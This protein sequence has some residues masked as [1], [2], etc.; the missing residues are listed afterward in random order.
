MQWLGSIRSG[1]ASVRLTATV[2]VTTVSLVCGGAWAA[3][4]NPLDD[5]SGGTLN[6]TPGNRHIGSAASNAVNSDTETDRKSDLIIVPIPGANPTIGVSLALAAAYFY[7]LDERSQASYT[8]IGA[9][10][11]TNGSLGWGLTQSISWLNDRLRAQAVIG[12]ADVRY[13]LY[14]VGSSAGGD[15]LRLPIDEPD[16]WCG[17]PDSGN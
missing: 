2:L 1:L 6:T 4:D 10:A 14:G 5:V 17:W 8:G 16:K 7:S 12:A 13:D 11:S 15:G 9:F 3:P